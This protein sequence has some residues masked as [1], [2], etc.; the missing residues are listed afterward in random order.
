MVPVISSLTGSIQHS[1]SL[2]ASLWT[3]KLLLCYCR[4]LSLFSSLFHCALCSRILLL[5]LNNDT[6]NDVITV[7]SEEN[8]ALGSLGF[9]PSF[10]AS[11]KLIYGQNAPNLQLRIC[12]DHEFCVKKKN[13]EKKKQLLHRKSKTKSQ[14]VSY[15]LY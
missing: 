2:C 1:L 8:P 3:I 4:S 6:P 11:D 5:L 7:H 10:E 15:W 9:S 14:V 13:W 12:C